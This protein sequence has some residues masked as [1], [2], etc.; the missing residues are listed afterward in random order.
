MFCVRLLAVYHGCCLSR[1]C[2]S[3]LETNQYREVEMAGSAV[4]LQTQ[5]SVSTHCKWASLLR[6]R[7][8]LPE[9]LFQSYAGS[10]ASQVHKTT[11][12]KINNIKTIKCLKYF[13][14]VRSIYL[15]HNYCAESINHSNLNL[16]E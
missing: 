10:Y 9:I 1:K 15:K 12:T 7:P 2:P 8:H 16:T 6:R 13:L 11:T 5:K 4:H 3:L 14:N